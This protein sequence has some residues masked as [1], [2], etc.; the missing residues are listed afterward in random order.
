MRAFSQIV[1]HNT[2]GIGAG[3]PYVLRLSILVNFSIVRDR[4]TRKARAVMLQR[5]LHWEKAS[6]RHIF[7]GHTDPRKLGNSLHDDVPFDKAISKGN[8]TV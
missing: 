1:A 4:L 8:K 3:R 5:T 6:W 2:V 7:F